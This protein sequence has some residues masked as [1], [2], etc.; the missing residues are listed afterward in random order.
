ME[1]RDSSTGE[2]RTWLANG[3]RDP[4]W[5]TF[6][7]H[8]ADCHNRPGHEFELPGEAADRAMAAGLIPATLPFAHKTAVQILK[9]AYASNDDA[10]KKIPL[11]FA[12]FTNGIMRV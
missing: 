9:A 3:A 7:M 10:V 8:C 4:G 11:A 6:T 12:A 2:T 1:Y 5:E